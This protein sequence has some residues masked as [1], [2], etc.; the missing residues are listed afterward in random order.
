[1]IRKASIAVFVIAFVVFSAETPYVRL[2]ANTKWLATCNSKLAQILI[3]TASDSK[4]KNRSFRLDW[5]DKASH[6]VFQTEY[7]AQKGDSIFAVGIGFGGKMSLLAKPY[8]VI[9]NTVKPGDTWNYPLASLGFS[10][11]LRFKAEGIDTL[12]MNGKKTAA[13][14][15][16]RKS[17]SM[18]QTRWYVRGAG[19]AMETGTFPNTP[20]DDSSKSNKQ[21]NFRKN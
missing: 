2:A 13:I 14:K 6:T 15:I 1:M 3:D 17:T 8:L 11:T 10:D 21:I 7:W 4:G 9:A 12:E 18:I 16:V 20:S 5:K 19:M